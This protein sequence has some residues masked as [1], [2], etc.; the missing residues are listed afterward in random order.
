MR[1]MPSAARLLEILKLPVQ[2]D[3]GQVAPRRAAPV[4]RIIEH[5]APAGPREWDKQIFKVEGCR[6]DDRLPAVAHDSVVQPHAVVRR[7]VAFS[8]GHV[9][10]PAAGEQHGE[11]DD[12]PAVA[13]RTPSLP[14]VSRARPV[15][16]AFT[17]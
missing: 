5:E 3:P 16:S 4:A 17:T 1:S 14:R 11:A 9:R 8:N 15:P 7:D 6:D 2:R 10:P 12:A 13:Q